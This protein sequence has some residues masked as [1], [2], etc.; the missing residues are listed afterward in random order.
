MEALERMAKEN[1]VQTGRQPGQQNAPGHTRLIVGIV[2]L[3]ALA[4][5]VVLAGIL[6]MKHAAAAKAKAGAAARAAQAPVPVVAG[7]VTEK[8]VPIYL[9]GLGT[10]QAFNTVTVHSRVDGELKK[11]AFVEGQ[12]VKAGDLLAQI[13][14]APYD[15][16]LGQAEGK[17]G[18]DAAQLENAQIDLKREAALFEAKID[19]EQVYATQQALVNQL[20]AAVKADV[21][22][23]ESAKVNL[24]YTKITSPIEGRTGIRLVD[25]GNIIHATD[26]NG[27]VVITQLKP[28]SVIFTL[29]AQTLGD[30]HKQMNSA[31]ELTV[32]AVD[33][34]NSTILAQ[35]KLS[36]IDNQIDTTTSTIKLKATF[37]NE[38]LKLW[39]GQFVNTRLQLNIRSNGI[40]V[41]TSV[42]QQGPTGAYAFVIQGEG[43]NLKVKQQTVTVALN[44]V[45]QPITEDGNTLVDSGLKP[46]DSVVVDGQYKLQDGSKVVEGPAGKGGGGNTATNSAVGGPIQ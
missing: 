12:D 11:V 5:F 17:R 32:L 45:N 18:Q 10:V 31:G 37:A 23:I 13:D 15:A 36:V 8:D 3:V 28:I 35:G 33:S 42:I 30:I 14:P 2:V 22:S 1:L 24:E 20:D 21:A 25:Q 41:P 29:P 9:D 16:A 26:T 40:M 6:V 44:P 7:K 38:D 39:P 27:L 43:S 19:S 34:D 4:V 46:G